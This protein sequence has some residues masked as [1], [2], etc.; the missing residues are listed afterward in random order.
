MI[1]KSK[2]FTLILQADTKPTFFIV[3]RA[4]SFEYLT[5]SSNAK[6]QTN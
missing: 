1:P 3:Y 4:F 5:K 2:T 6:V